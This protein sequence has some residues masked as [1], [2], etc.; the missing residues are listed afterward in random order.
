MNNLKAGFVYDIERIVGGRVVDK[1]RAHN[2]VPIEGLNYLLNTAM[3]GGVAYTN[4]YIGL[5]EGNYSPVPEDT[6]ATFPLAA[7]ELTAY[8][9]G[10]RPAL[11]LGDV[12]AGT[13]DNSLAKAE[14]TGT[15]NGKMVQGGFITT[16]PVKGASTGILLSAVRF[17]SPQPLN[18]A[19]ILRVTAGFSIVSV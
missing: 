17:P 14:F 2:L 15:T 19:G 10:T 7:T 11:S 8:Q 1:F 18:N 9:A 16:S 4:F 3:K 6:M 12:A 5:Y 13:V